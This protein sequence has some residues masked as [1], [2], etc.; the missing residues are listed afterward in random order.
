MFTSHGKPTLALLAALT[1]AA[2]DSESGGLIGSG[3]GSRL[4]VQITDA[5]ADLAEANV[6]VQ[7]IVLIRSQAGEGSGS[8]RVELTPRSTDWIDL[9]KLDNGKVQDLVT[10][11]VEPGSYGQVRLIVCDMYIKTK[12]GQIVAT[13]GTTLPTG[14]TATTGTELRLTSQCQSGFKV[15]FAE[16]SVA[17][18]AGTNTLII[19]FDVARSFAHEAGR[20]GKWI[21]T[22]VLHGVKREQGGTITGTVALQGITLPLSCGAESLTQ[23]TLLTRVHPTATAGTIVRSARAGADGSYRISNVAAGTYVL[24]VEQVTFPNGDKLNFTATANPASVAVAAGGS[25]TSNLS[26][27]AATCVKA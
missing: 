11:T 13:S 3:D 18:A 27:T 10:E 19:D 7:K 14:V 15:N 26:V 5:P 20:S 6:K 21:V 22:P 24:G 17:V 23:T 4:T 16:G 25:T 8:D 12:S 1:F 9:L 2:C